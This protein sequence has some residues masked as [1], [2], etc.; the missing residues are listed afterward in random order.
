MVIYFYFKGKRM[1]KR[2]V[3][4]VG[5]IVGALLL[6]ACQSGGNETQKQQKV[7]VEVREV[8]QIGKK[9]MYA[10][11]PLQQ[12]TVL[13]AGEEGM[14]IAK[15]DTGSAEVRFQKQYKSVG[16]PFTPPVF[17]SYDQVEAKHRSN[18]VVD[19][20]ETNVS[21]PEKPKIYT[22]LKLPD[23]ILVGG[24]FAT[25]NGEKHDNIV[26][27]KYDGSID[28]SF[29]AS[30]EG[31]VYKII[32][33]GKDI[34][35]AGVFGAYNGSEAY[36]I[37]KVDKNGAQVQ[38]FMPF[39]DYVLAKIN[40]ID[41]YGDGKI[42]AVGTFVKEIGDQDENST[43]EELLTMTKCV[44]I[45]NDDGTID[46]EESKKFDDIR[47]EA[48]AL[49]SDEERLYIGGD[50]EFDKTGRH[51]NGLVAYMKNG[52]FDP[53]FHI[54]KLNGMV[55]DVAVSGDKLVFGGD[56]IAEKDN[57]RNR[58]FYIVDKLSGKTLKVNSFT[59]DAD[60]YN[61][62]VY[63]GNIV[64]SGEGEFKVG[65]KSLKNSIVMNIN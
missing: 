63:S 25:V 59:S 44:L 21:K 62:D 1:D 16:K 43:K 8:T 56:F 12:D 15:I 23:G 37:V 10:S 32:K 26:K 35:I 17:E 5:T 61:V 57:T 30:A 4:L 20:N 42:I 65:D 52:E 9:N 55:F 49:T 48:F 29:K 3:G 6:Q 18:K 64:V 39:K 14:S 46:R 33:S 45:L 27:L 24:K 38:D 54:Q 19:G 36:S 34:F 13:M 31:A 2:S 51:Y 40:D 58:S 60:I 50:F 7:S 41:A 11:V 22:M 47:N 28:R 53:N